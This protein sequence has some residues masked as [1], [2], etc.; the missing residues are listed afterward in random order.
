MKY[1]ILFTLFISNS[2]ACLNKINPSELVKVLQANDPSIAESLSYQGEDF[3]CYDNIDLRH[4][5][6]LIS[7]PKYVKMIME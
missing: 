6:L 7:L 4:F 5:D 3:V 2:Y 1:L